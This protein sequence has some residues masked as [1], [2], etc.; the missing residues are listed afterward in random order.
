MLTRHG[1]PANF[2]STSITVA[3]LAEIVDGRSPVALF[4]PLDT[5]VWICID[6]DTVCT[7]DQQYQP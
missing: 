6:G 5:G 2:G 7:L 3:Q 1:D 4:E